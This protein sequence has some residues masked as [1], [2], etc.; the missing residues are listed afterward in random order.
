MRAGCP[1]LHAERKD[2]LCQFCLNLFAPLKKDHS[3]EC[4]KTLH[5]FKLPTGSPGASR[6]VPGA[7][8]S[9]SSTA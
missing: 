4:P 8:L 7:P 9:L 2:V 1:I 3:H 6:E 5:Q